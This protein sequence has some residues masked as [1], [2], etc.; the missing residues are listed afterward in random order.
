[1]QIMESVRLT[2]RGRK[3]FPDSMKIMLQ[4]MIPSRFHMGGKNFYSQ[5]LSVVFL[6]IFVCISLAFVTDADENEL[7]TTYRD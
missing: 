1:M 6:L 7:E 2:E 4:A 3:R 5:T